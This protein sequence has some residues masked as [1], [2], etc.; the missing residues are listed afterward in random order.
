MADS[1]T[2]QDR[3][4]AD[5]NIT[6]L[7]DVLPVLLVIFM[8]AAPALSHRIELSPPQ[9]SRDPAS[10]GAS[11]ARAMPAGTGPSSHCRYCGA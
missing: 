6:P 9:P 5:I 1:A 8:I 7:I 2:S 10:A 11:M 4:L 3:A